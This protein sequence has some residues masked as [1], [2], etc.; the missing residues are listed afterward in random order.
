MSDWSQ[1]VRDL[2]WLEE[3][4]AV[5]GVAAV[6]AERRRQIEK[7]GYTTEHDREHATGALA[8]DATI[9][10]AGAAYMCRFDPAAHEAIPELASAA[11]LAAAEIDQVTPREVITDEAEIARMLRRGRHGTA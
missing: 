6:V 9:R 2:H 8:T 3:H 7:H 5:A 11:A 10:L 4:G 1:A